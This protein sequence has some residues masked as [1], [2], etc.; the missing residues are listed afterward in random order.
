MTYRRVHLEQQA[1]TLLYGSTIMLVACS[2]VLGIEAIKNV[3]SYWLPVALGLCGVLL[4]LVASALLI[5]DVRSMVKLMHQEVAVTYSD[6][7]AP[8]R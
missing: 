6:I 8:A 5:L 7:G 2:F 1:L 3:L 4:M